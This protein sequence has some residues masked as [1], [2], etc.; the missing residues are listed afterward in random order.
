[1]IAP[2]L[3]AVRAAAPACRPNLWCC[4][5]GRRGYRVK[6][7]P[8][9]SSSRVVA[10]PLAAT[11]LLCACDL[12]VRPTGERPREGARPAAAAAVQS[13]PPPTLAPAAAL[14]VTPAPALVQPPTPSP[15]AAAAGPSPSPSI[16]PIFSNLQPAP[17]ATLPVGDVVIG[18]RVTTSVDLVDL[19]LYLNDEPV[20][21]DVSRPGERVKSVSI[22]R[23]L[24]AGIHDVRV[25][26]RDQQGQLGGYRWQFTVGS[27]GRRAGATPPPRP[28]IAVPTVG[29][30]A[31]PTQ[32]RPPLPTPTP[33]QVGR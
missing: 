17:G 30:P 33:R 19:V 14:R 4:P 31:A 7:F 22:V 13:G 23:R 10:V 8:R 20:P 16:Y 29:P 25:Q 18:A 11:L 21:Q 12:T 32:S 15:V 9:L 27:A 24:A 6:P 1:M 26:A 5:G 3:R 28:T 2:P